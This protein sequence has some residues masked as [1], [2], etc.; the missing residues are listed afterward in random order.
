MK[1]KKTAQKNRTTY[2][3]YDDE[4]RF[5]TEYKPGKDGI[6]EEIIQAMHRMDDHDVYINSKENRHPEWFQAVYDRWK[7]DFITHFRE[8]YGRNPQRDEIPYRFRRCESI[9]AQC[10][11]DGEELNDSSRLEEEMAVRDVM[12]GDEPLTAVDYMRELVGGMPLQWQKV[13]QLVFREELTKAD[14]AEKIGISAARVGQL[15][16]KITVELTENDDL[17]KYFR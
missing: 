6:T 9:E 12:P 3:L 16:K 10:D 17:K 4:G 11:V 14:A 5:V 1:T 7:A 15:V 8:I 13:Y 2:R